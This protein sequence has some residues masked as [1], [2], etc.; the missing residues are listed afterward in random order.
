[1]P[2]H[3]GFEYSHHHSVLFFF[4]SL[5]FHEVGTETLI[6]RG[7]K[8][9][10][11]SHERHARTWRNCRLSPCSFGTK[12]AAVCRSAGQTTMTYRY[13][14]H[15]HFSRTQAQRVVGRNRGQARLTAS[16]RARIAKERGLRSRSRR[17]FLGFLHILCMPH[18]CRK[19]SN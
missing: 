17:G 15:V 1:M 16:T 3:S 11:I 6:S 18:V 8:E 10:A 14:S 9:R 13:G 2:A 5:F 7:T 19:K 12:A 4:I